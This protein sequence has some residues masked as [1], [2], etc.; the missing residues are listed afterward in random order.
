M[1]LYNHKE[2]EKKWQ[3]KWA[4]DGQN[5]AI[6]GSKK[7]KMYL[8][9]EFPYPSGDGLHVGHARSYTALDIVARKKRAEGFNV[10]YPIGWD[11]FGLPTENYALKTGI[12]PKEVTKQNTDKFREQLKS[13]GF[14]FDWDREINT[15]DPEYYKWTQWIFIKLFEKGLAY[16]SK[17]PINWCIDC[18]TG[19]ANE[20]VIDGL[21]E[22]CGGETER[23]EKEQ[24]MLKITNYAQ[25]LYDDLDE[26]DYLDRIKTQQRNWIGRSEGAEI[27]FRIAG[28]NKKVKVFTTR[29]D[30]LFGAT[31]VVLAPEHELLKDNKLGITNYKEVEE[32]V[33]EAV[34]KPEIERT[35]EG[36]EKTGVELKGVKAINPANSEEIPIFIADYVLSGYGTGAIMAVPAHDERD[37]Q[38]A[39]KF[40]L[41]IQRVIANKDIVR[42]IVWGHNIKKAD[43]ESIGVKIVEEIKTNN[44]KYDEIIKK[45]EFPVSTIVAFEKLVQEKL[46]V[47]FWNEYVGPIGIIFNFKN[48]DNSISTYK[49]DSSNWAE[50]D[51]K[52][53]EFFHNKKV[54]LE[55]KARNVWSWLAKAENGFYKNIIIHSNEGMLEN[56]EKFDGLT[57]EDAKE[58]ITKFVGG[59]MK[60]TYKLR[61]WIFSRQR[62]WGEPIPMINCGKCGWVPVPEDSLPLELPEVENYKPTDDGES[63]LASAEDWVN[64]TCP[65]CNGS[66]KRETDTMPNWAGSSW[67]FLRY[68]DPKN[69]DEFAGKDKLKYWTPVDWYNGGMEHTTLHL[70]YSR[71]WHKFLYDIGIVP[72]SEPYMKRTSQGMILAEDGSKMSKSKGN[73]INP[74]YVIKTVGADTLRIYEMFM[75][76]FDQTIIWNTD[77]I[78]GARR[79]LEKMWNYYHNDW[80]KNY[81]DDNGKDYDLDEWDNSFSNLLHNTIKKVNDDIDQMK[82]NTAVSSLMVLLNNI[83]EED[84]TISH[85]VKVTNT[86]SR[87]ITTPQLETIFKLVAPFAPHITEELWFDLQAKILKKNDVTSIHL[88]K[89]PQFDESKLVS[90]TV[91][92][93]VQINGKTRGTIEANSGISKDDAIKLV[94]A[95]SKFSKWLEGEAKKTFYVENKLIN[96]VI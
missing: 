92:I 72:S 33:K 82:F 14:S 35:A 80:K 2:V 77:N 29:P 55:W 67:Y 84:K 15:T 38:F 73:A 42:S 93:A 10:L 16:K 30:T 45:V 3:D 65:K 90:G 11:A 1:S 17:M 44:D 27:D 31:Y 12:H 85:K 58:K 26:V 32:Y 91:F 23:R 68:T 24:W 39:D 48:T 53:Y 86:K 25:R 4:E 66:A 47:G 74:D 7:E 50:V 18:K 59:K 83:Y 40:D 34:S 20:E 52:C 96:I 22:R 36:K 60:T 19:L 56:S 63:P 61:D 62:Y 95:D 51:K 64:T 71:F 6:D 46:P 69:E 89:W 13:M 57:S 43:L 21:C 79:F 78:A 54:G 9:V 5:K 41:P 49:L 88:E 76:P 28:G 70:L 81:I 8:L 94:R 87:Q 37:Y 75:G